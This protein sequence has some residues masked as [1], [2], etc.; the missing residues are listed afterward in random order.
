MVT[1]S[2]QVA[3]SNAVTSTYLDAQ[4]NPISSHSQLL[5]D[6]AE[7]WTWTRATQRRTHVALSERIPAVSVLFS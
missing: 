1:S 6:H 2:N 7:E 5:S 4:S 3:T